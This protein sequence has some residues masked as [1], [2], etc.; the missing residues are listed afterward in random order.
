M[1]EDTVGI[2]GPSLT[3]LKRFPKSDPLLLDLLKPSSPLPEGE[4]SFMKVAIE[5]K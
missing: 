4:D 5:F 2:A 1:A 3:E